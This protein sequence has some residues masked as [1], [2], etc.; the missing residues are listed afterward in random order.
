MVMSCD[1]FIPF[2]G[3]AEFVAGASP[4]CL[5][6]IAGY[7]DKSPAHR[8]DLTDGRCH[9]RCQLH[10]R[11]SF[12]LKDISTCSSAQLWTSD[13]LMTSRPALP[14]ELQLPFEYGS[15]VNSTYE[16]RYRVSELTSEPPVYSFGSVESHTAASLLNPAGCR[17]PGPALSDGRGWNSELRPEKH[18]WSLTFCRPT[19]WIKDKW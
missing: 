18:S 6:A 13:L 9:A 7:L 14:T 19:I 8:R 3:V 17:C 5:W 10:I 16:I 15:L 4:S 1:R 2:Y 11:S 12:L